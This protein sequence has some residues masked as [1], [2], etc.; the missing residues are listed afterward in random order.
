MQPLHPH[1]HFTKFI[2]FFQKLKNQ[3]QM[4][5]GIIILPIWYY[6]RRFSL[7]LKTYSASWWTKTR[8]L[9]GEAEFLLF[10]SIAN[11]RAVL[12]WISFK[13]FGWDF[14]IICYTLK[15][16]HTGQRFSLALLLYFDETQNVMLILDL[17]ILSGA[18]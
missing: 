12:S 11:W 9:K 6:F 3:P 13:L 1:I 10:Y 5:Q 8:F 4:S 2:H 14:I 16:E 18:C 15:L 17:A 7:F